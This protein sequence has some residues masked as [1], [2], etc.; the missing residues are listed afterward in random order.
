[1]F[2]QSPKNT[3][4]NNEN[5]DLE[6]VLFS[7]G[8]D[9]SEINIKDQDTELTITAIT[10]QPDIVNVVEKISGILSPYFIVLVG[11]YL[12]D[13]NFLIGTLLIFTG[14]FSLLKLSW[15]DLKNALDQIKNFFS[16]DPEAS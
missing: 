11:L 8:G 10:N 15:K 9:K 3:E 1:M 2:G 5:L 13:N 7:Q 16:A 14:I 6:S 12:Y 4:K